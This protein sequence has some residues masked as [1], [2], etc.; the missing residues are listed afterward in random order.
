MLISAAIIVR[1]EADSLDACLTSIADLVDEIVVVDTGSVDDSPKVARA[2]GAMVDAMAWTGDFSGP[3]NRSLDLARGRWIL[4]IDADERLRPGDHGSARAV[5]EADE[6]HRAFRI[7][8][9]PRVGWTPYREYRLWRHDPALRF[10]GTIH[11]TMSAALAEMAAQEGR[12]VGVLDSLT[13]DHFGYEGDQAHKY[14]RDE[15]MLRQALAEV[16]ERVFYYDHLARILEAQGRDEEAESTWRQGI[17]IARRRSRPVPDDRLLW[18]NLLVH[19]LARDRITPE[20]GELIDDALARFPQNP[21]LEL[22]AA[23]HAFVSGRPA[24]AIPRL[25][26]LLGLTPAF[27]LDSQSAY[28]RRVIEEWPW[29]LLGLCRFRLGDD[30]GAAEAFA[31]AEAAAPEVADYRARRLLAA[32]RAAR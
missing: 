21:A 14:A 6:D 11:E 32:A 26:W 28:D 31:R 23:T 5:L 8:F 7:P 17:E 24:E 29:N 1:D 3:R 25:E 18:I 20:L 19:L 10:R 4:Y 27:L 15:P 22:T 2:H 12:R 13:I 30:A 16:P 9:V